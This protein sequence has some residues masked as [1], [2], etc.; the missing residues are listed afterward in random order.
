MRTYSAALAL[1]ALSLGVWGCSNSGYPSSPGAPSPSPGTAVII[2][3]VAVNGSLSFSPN[4]ATIPAG[5]MVIWH[6]VDT[7]THRVVLDDLVNDTGNLARGAFSAPTLI[8]GT[9][10]YHCAVHPVMVG[11]IKG[12]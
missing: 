11:T 1:A 6:N 2:D 7:I 8:G 5:Q 10:A 3:V 4:P 9:G 12:Q